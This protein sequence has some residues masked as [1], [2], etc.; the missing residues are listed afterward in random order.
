VTG[1]D[2]LQAA[3]GIEVCAPVLDVIAKHGQDFNQ[4]AEI[5]LR[6][7]TVA[8]GK[9]QEALHALTF[10]LGSNFLCAEA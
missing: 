4:M 6:E 3:V 2:H 8:N 5:P 7:P 1:F 9:F 10:W